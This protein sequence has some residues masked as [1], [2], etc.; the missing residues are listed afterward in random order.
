M[1]GHHLNAM[2]AQQ[3]QAEPSSLAQ[4]TASNASTKISPYGNS[5]IKSWGRPVKTQF[6][7]Q[8]QGGGELLNAEKSLIV[9]D[10]TKQKKDS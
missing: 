4:I 6:Q 3:R 8:S 9:T 1:R 7:Q 5:Q 2:M 10:S